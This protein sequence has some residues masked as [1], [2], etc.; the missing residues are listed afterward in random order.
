MYKVIKRLFDIIFSLI[1][2]LILFPVLLICFIAVKVSSPGPAIFKQT[3]LCKNGKEF[4][5]YKFRSMYINSEHTGTGVYSFKGDKRVTKIGNILR[6]TSLDELPQLI[7]IIK[8]EMSFI[9]PRPVL[10]YHPWPYEEY[11]DEQKR[12]FNVRPGITGLAQINGRKA[13]QWDKRLEFDVH[14]ADNLSLSM[15]ISIFFKTIYSVIKSESNENVG[16]TVGTKK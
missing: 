13:A 11:S 9:G 14:Y 15:D 4:T 12:R 7:N 6:K 10:T 8:G 5:M 2:L 3:R 1:L 16:E